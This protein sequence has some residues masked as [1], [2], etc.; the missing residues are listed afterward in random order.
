[1]VCFGREARHIGYFL[2]CALL[3]HCV[4]G[5]VRWACGYFEGRHAVLR[6]RTPKL[7]SGF[8][9]ICIRS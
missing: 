1:M 7:H 3:D 6:Q 2:L 5:L 8:L 9:L 4:L